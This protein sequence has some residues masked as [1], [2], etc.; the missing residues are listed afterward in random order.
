MARLGLVLLV[1]AGAFL[2]P[3]SEPDLS[4]RGPTPEGLVA[5]GVQGAADRAVLHDNERPAGIL[6]NGVLRIHLRAVEA[7]WR[8][9]GDDRPGAVVFAFAEGSGPPMIPSPLLRVPLGTEIHATLENTLDST[10]VVRGLTERVGT[11]PR[12][13]VVAP[14]ERVE[15]RFTADAPGTYPYWGRVAAEPEAAGPDIRER[16]GRD[17]PLSGALVV[18]PP[19][20]GPVET[21][22]VMVITLYGHRYP[23]TDQTSGLHT[24]NGRPWPYTRRL[25]YTQGDTVRWRIVN[26]A[27]RGHPMHLHGFFFRVDAKGDLARDSIFWE[28]ERR[29]AV[30]EEMPPEST[31]TLTWSPDRPGGWVFHCH[32]AAHV[33]TNLP[34][35]DVPPDPDA[36]MRELLLGDAHHDPDQHV[37]QGMGGLMV[38]V[39]VLPAPGWT[40]DERERRVIR[41]AIVSDSLPAEADAAVAFNSPHRRRF[42]M[43]VD[44]SGRGSAVPFPGEALLLEEGEPTTI[45]VVNRSPEPTA[46]HWHGLE[47]E[48]LYDGVVG[49]GGY[50]GS[51]TP[52]V[53]PGD[54]FQVRITPPRSGSFMYHTHMSDVRQ[55]GGGLYGPFVVVPDREA[56][57]PDRDRIFLLGNGP[58]AGGVFL[59]GDTELP[60]TRMIPGQSYRLRFMNITLNN[61]GLRVRV[62]RDGYP[63]RWTP[64]AKDGADL[65]GE[66]R[67]TELAEFGIRVGETA[68]F[69][70][71]PD[72]GVY[73]VEV[74][75]GGGRLLASQRV[76]VD[77][78]SGGA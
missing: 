57:D 58:H 33:Q 22:E 69:R 68:D 43:V 7:D 40:P 15:V 31:L 10:L 24:I 26:L 36:R 9:M 38:G 6:E 75:A 66:W 70:F 2:S 23:G 35:G 13:V 73:T 60:E 65:P 21:E 11:P 64:L 17:V 62:V 30:T 37:E 12:A 45:W 72:P 19:G 51:R 1:A 63:S 39:D 78:P 49:V 4:T 46:I 54:S 44:G 74:R 5:V 77:D 27:E 29:M 55:Q 50:L 48:S 8:P 41:A 53:L 56:W 67:D 42:S 14:G 47:L 18:D 25:Q 16:S 34:L 32:I 28:S 3:R 59:N 76:V 20:E 71:E 61:N 52:A